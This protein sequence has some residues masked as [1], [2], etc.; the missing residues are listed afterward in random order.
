MRAL[1]Y[2][3]RTLLQTPTVALIAVLTL[4]LGVGASTAIFSVV[5]AVLLRPLPFPQP[6]QLI[7]VRESSRQFP[8]MSVSFPDYLDWVASN[9]SFQALAAYRGTGAVITHAGPPAVISGQDATWQY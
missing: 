8:S 4:G 6:E 3:L 1:R 5:D 9:H 7:S 2:A